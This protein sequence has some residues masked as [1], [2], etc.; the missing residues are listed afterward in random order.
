MRLLSIAAAWLMLFGL[1]RAD[2]LVI[3]ERPLADCRE[4]PLD[5]KSGVPLDLATVLRAISRALCTTYFLPAGL[6]KEKVTLTLPPT[7]SPHEREQRILGALRAQGIELEPALSAYEVHKISDGRAAAP[8]TEDPAYEEAIRTGVRCKDSRC[9][10]KRATW[11][12]VLSRGEALARSA[13]VVPSMRDGKPFGFKLLGIRPN[14]LFARLGFENGDT[15]LRVD[16]E[17]L[18]SP[19]SALAVYQLLRQSRRFAV[20][21]DRRG[22]PFTLEVAIVE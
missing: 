17:E 4:A 16:G 8:A 13:R 12:L 5:V 1:V 14:T 21:V 15:L 6:A 2:E 10:I 22:A 20:A 3:H 7:K 18:A 11:D 19:E 9:E